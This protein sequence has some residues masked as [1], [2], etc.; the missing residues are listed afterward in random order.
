MVRLLPPYTSDAPES[1]GDTVP[2]KIYILS[3][4]AQRFDLEHTQP[5]THILPHS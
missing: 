3:F 2:N 5:I 1:T 4:D